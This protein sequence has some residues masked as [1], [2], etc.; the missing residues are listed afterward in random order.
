[1]RVN[2]ERQ[3]IVLVGP[4]AAER[5]RREQHRRSRRASP[6]RRSPTSATARW[7]R[8]GARH[9]QPRPDVAGDAVKRCALVRGSSCSRSSCCCCR[10]R[11]R[12][13][14]RAQAARQPVR[15][16]DLGRIDGWRD[17]A[18]VGYGLV[19]GLA[20]TG[21]SPRNRA[22]RQSIANM[23][24]QF[25]MTSGQRPG[26]EPQR[27]RGDGDARRCRR[28]RAQASA[29]DVTVTSIGDA[30]SLVGG[31]LLLTPLKGADDRVHALAQ[32]PLSVGGYK[33]DAARQRG[34]EEPSDRRRWSRPGAT[35]ERG[36]R[37][38]STCR[39]SGT[40]AVR[41]G[42][43]RLHDR[44]ARRRLR[45]TG[46]S[47]RGRR[48]RATRRASRSAVPASRRRRADGGAV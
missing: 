22:T 41:A 44:R 47:A 9:H 24:S 17:N 6:T 18:L 30:R 32:G 42:R 15:V 43:A 48:S 23:L 10:R 12:P 34:A 14:R 4:R 11:S 37:D 3:E 1:M 45:S 46:R 25:G 39:R 20:G 27:R 7:A 26:A 16:K 31:T 40:R 13:R 21:D 28:S 29:L 2:D 8:S 33:Y 38:A 36:G 35:V 19:T 5:H